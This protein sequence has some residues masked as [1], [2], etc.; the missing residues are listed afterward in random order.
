MLQLVDK[1]LSQALAASPDFSDMLFMPGQPVQ[2]ES[3]GKL[4]TLETRPSLGM[5]S[6]YHTAFLAAQ[7]CSARQDATTSLT[8]TG[9][10][11]LA[12]RHSTGIRFRV[13]IFKR[14]GGIGIVMRQLPRDIPTIESLN[15]PS[16]FADM[17][18]SRAGLALVTGPTGSGKTTSLAAALQHVA[19][20]RPVHVVTLED[21]IE[22]VYPSQKDKKDS[23][24]GP[25]PVASFSQRE[26]G[27][28]FFHFA[29]GLRAALR[30]APKIILVG[31]IRDRE[32]MDIAMQA[33]E[34]GHL[35]MGTLHT[36]GAGETINRIV[37]MFD[38][39]EEQLIRQRLA[40]SLQ[41]VVSQRLLPATN[42]KRVAAFEVMRSTLRVREIILEKERPDRTYAQILQDG[43]PSN[44]VFFDDYIVDLYEEGKIT[45]DT[46][47]FAATEQS[48]MTQLLDRIRNE[49]GL[50]TREVLTL[51]NPEDEDDDV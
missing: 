38:P 41:F 23:E 26:L 4:L 39:Q 49:R 21:P 34:T 12:Y 31:E 29:Q 37:G 5:L 8:Q 6:S 43:R 15:L 51:E 11:D 9:S 30:Q 50:N 19:Y 22:F 48:R 7:L 35:V 3:S 13:N 27:T 14:F 40:S 42:G 28:D 47:R 24:E 46:A 36:S 44:M 2:I 17:A 25:L 32:T 16:V 33:A 10:M 20:H 45:E 18:M 1:L